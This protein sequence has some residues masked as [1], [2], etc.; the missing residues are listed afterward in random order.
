[1][2]GLIK[3]ADG[4]SLSARVRPLAGLRDADPREP[5]AP[6][7]ALALRR[8]IEQ[9]QAALWARDEEVV[10]LQAEAVKAFADGEAQ[11]RRKGMAESD[12]RR[13][14][15]LSRLERGVDKAVAQFAAGMAGLETLSL[16]LAH[17]AL[18]KILDDPETLSPLLASAI[19]R[20]LAGLEAQAIVRIVVSPLDFPTPVELE[21]LCAKIGR[22]E[23]ALQTSEELGAGEGRIVL[24]LGGLEVGVRQ[25]WARLS[26]SL[27]ALAA[28]E[29][30]A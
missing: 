16:Q 29:A 20:Q 18:A 14:T 2:T 10:R 3:A 9:V 22:R 1:M 26:Q 19:R 15:Y 4:A 21:T 27:Q 7:E 8:E 11:G 24:T 28:A 12:E 30:D 6:S 13:S 17:T 5:A 25:Q 23:L